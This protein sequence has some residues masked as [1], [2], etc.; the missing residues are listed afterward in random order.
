MFENMTL[1]EFNKAVETVASLNISTANTIAESAQ[2]LKPL[3]EIPTI[4]TTAT[5]TNQSLYFDKQA[6]QEIKIPMNNEQFENFR[7]F[8]GLE[9]HSFGHRTIK[10][11][12]FNEPATIVFWGDGTKT[13]SKCYDEEYNKKKGLLMCIA[14]GNG[15]CHSKIKSKLK[16]MGLKDSQDAELCL[17]YEIAEHF[18]FKI[19]DIE[20]IVEKHTK[21]EE[22]K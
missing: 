14:K 15:I 11:V 20:T 9:C 6:Q 19:A 13:V 17:L 3:S 5:R 8:V 7:K 16:R 10:R 18:R 12:I 2:I 22:E 4:T 21:K 1:E